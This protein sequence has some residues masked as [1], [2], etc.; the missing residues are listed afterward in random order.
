MMNSR[1]S[2]FKSSLPQKQ[3]RALLY[4]RFASYG[5]EKDAQRGYSDDELEQI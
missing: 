4:P 3:S 5:L 1:G 2:A